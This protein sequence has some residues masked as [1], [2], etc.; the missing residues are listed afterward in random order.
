[1][2]YIYA[3]RLPYSKDGLIEVEILDEAEVYDRL[4][5][6][7]GL[8]NQFS[9]VEK[10]IQFIDEYQIFDLSGGEAITVATLSGEILFQAG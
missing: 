6:K 8:V 10:L 5:E 7:I 4:H 2:K 1:M 3:Y 9:S